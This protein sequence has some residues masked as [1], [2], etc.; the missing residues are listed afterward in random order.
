MDLVQDDDL[1]AVAGGAVPQ[2]LGQ[3]ADLLHLRVGGGVDL[4]HVEI[5]RFPDLG[6][7]QAGVARFGHRAPGGAVGAEAVQG[8][9]EDSRG[10][11]LADAADAGEEIGLRDA[12]VAQCVAQ[13]GDDRLLA[14][15]VG[16]R[17]R[18]PLAG[19]RLVGHDLN[20]APD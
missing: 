12:A 10:R 19:Q 9:G 14:D 4:D 7:D 18:P 1:V 11:R 16:E 2:A 17:L 8:L 20:G 3:V 15:Q 13:G 6:A 5:A